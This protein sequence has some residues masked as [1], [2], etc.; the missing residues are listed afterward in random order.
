MTKTT[1]PW[2]QHQS[3]RVE[4]SRVWTDKARKTMIAFANTYGG[5]L[6][7]GVKDDGKGVGVENFDKIERNVFDFA[8]NDVE[9][10]MSSLI[11][12]TPITLPDGKTVAAVQVL[13]GDERPYAF[14]NKSW[15]NGGVFI[16][17]GSSSLQAERSEIMSMAKDLIPWEERIARR[18]DLT[19]E[20]AQHICEEQYALFYRAEFESYGI[21]DRHGRFTNF[22]LLL[23]DQ[24]PETIRVNTFFGKSGRYTGG[25]EL[26]G[27]IL[28]QR[29]DALQIL[30]QHN[31]PRS[32]EWA[33]WD[34][35][36][37]PPG[38]VCEALTNCIVHRNFNIDLSSPTLVNIFDD[39]MVV[40]TVATLPE[41]LTI[42]DLYRVGTSFCR[43]RFLAEFFQRLHWI[44]P[45]GRG[46]SE[47]FGGY[48]GS[49]LKPW[50][51]C[52]PRIFTITLPKLLEPN[53]LNEKIAVLIR[54]H[55]SFSAKE[56][57][58]KVNI[59]RSTLNKA[60]KEL[61]DSKQIIRIG[62]G[63]S[64]RYTSRAVRGR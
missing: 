21:T 16:R 15:T 35:R 31:L 60:L 2:G 1:Q 5:T 44:D 55:G 27:S 10:D 43:N 61:V 12:V 58:G 30:E 33:D 53:S 13:F 63:R 14:K 26:K 47:I 62:D 20:A 18:Q 32:V 22:G 48:A 46:F 34:E 40:M 52:S 23:S 64:T 45:A 37:W 3:E 4:F 59:A 25:T 19:F 24:N 51:D 50:C 54:E 11:R 36:P 42:K 28:K 8:R 38:A 17:V 57:Q 6:Y 7:L 49:P 9:P 29:E 41:G 39:R 56:L